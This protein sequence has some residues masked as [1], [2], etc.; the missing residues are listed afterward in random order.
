MKNIYPFSG[1]ESTDS[2]YTYFVPAIVLIQ[3]LQWC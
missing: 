2:L 1:S 3:W